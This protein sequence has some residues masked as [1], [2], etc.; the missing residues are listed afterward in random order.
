MLTVVGELRVRDLVTTIA[1]L[2][3]V[4]RAAILAETGA[5]VVTTRCRGPGFH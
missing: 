3:T 4:G 2:N 1:G 5:W